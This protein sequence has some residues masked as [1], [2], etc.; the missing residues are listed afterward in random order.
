MLRTRRLH[1]K[2]DARPIH[3]ICP[4]ASMALTVTP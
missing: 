1:G 4:G 3:C 2:R